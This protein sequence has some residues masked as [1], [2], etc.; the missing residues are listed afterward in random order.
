MSFSSALLRNVL[1]ALAFKTN[2]KIIVIESDDWGS[3]RMPS[4]KVYK[5]LLDKNLIDGN[6][7]F[8]KYDSLESENDLIGLFEV[9]SSVKD[10]NGNPAKLTANC[11]M[12][13]PDF[14]K[15]ES[16]GFMSYHYEKAEVSFKRYPRHSQSLKLWFEGKEKHVFMPQLHGR[17]HV[18][19]GLWMNALQKS[20]SSYRAAFEFKTFAIN[21][22]IVEALARNDFSQG[23]LDPSSTVKEAAHMFAELFEKDSVSF[24]A[25]NYTWDANIEDALKEVGINFLQ[26]S[27][28][29]NIKTSDNEK[30]TQYHYTGQKNK[31]KQVYL[32]RNCLFEPS[33]SN[34]I[35]YLD[36]CLKQIESAFKWNT[37]AII[38]S[39]RLNFLGELDETNRSKNLNLLKE[40]LQSAT[41]KWPDI[42]FMST[43]ELSLHIAAKDQA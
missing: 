19:A 29:Q 16:S 22:K 3:I 36:I 20:D 26:G 43:D 17:E 4:Q 42:E 10:K 24:I 33:V 27:K 18:N 8:L 6:D 31:N 7:S 12:A 23:A 2:R 41:K 39:H 25:P 11:I 14:D 37:P 21:S 40:L 1:N 28:K 13:N 5:Q 35:N 15:I 30:K 34:K 38:T 9:L 32:V